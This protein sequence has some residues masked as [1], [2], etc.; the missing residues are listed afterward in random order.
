MNLRRRAHQVG[1]LGRPG[2]S[3]DLTGAAVQSAITGRRLPAGWDIFPAM[4][5]TSYA[6]ARPSGLTADGLDLQASGGLSANP[7]LFAGFM[8]TPQ[9]VAAGLL[10]AADVARTRYFQ[11]TGPGSL[12]PVVTGSAAMLRFESFSGCCGVYARP[13]VLP[14]G[15]DGRM[16]EHGTGAL[17]EVTR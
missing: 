6:Y 17:A 10:A 2:S 16:L 7:R 14:S 3:A 9:P 4:S 13:D 11:P 15:L 1:L 12:D 5:T 8:T